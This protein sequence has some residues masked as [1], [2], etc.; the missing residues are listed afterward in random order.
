M[1]VVIAPDSFKECATAAAVSKAIAA[2]WLR[3]DPNADCVLVPMADGGEGTM[4]ALLAG[5]GEPLTVTVTG[6]LGE[7]VQAAYGLIHEGS[8]AVLEMAQAAGLA[9]VPPERRDP[10][11]TTTRGVGEMICHAL[12]RGVRKFLVGI[13]G[14][15][16]NDGGAG[17]AQALGYSLL[18]ADGRELP[19]GGAALVR[20]AHVDIGKRHPALQEC[21]IM[22]ACDVDNPLCGSRGASAVYGP[23]KGAT[24]SMVKELDA[25]LAHFA[26]VVKAKVPGS[27]NQDL[28]TIPGAGA[29]GGLGFGLL[30]FCGARMRR[31]VELVAEAAGLSEKVARADLV[32]TGEGRMDGQSAS[33]KTPVGVA[34]IARSHGVPVVALIGSLGSGYEAVY[35]A[36]IDAVV[37]ICPGPVALAE[38]M[39]NG[40]VLI[41]DAAERLARLWRVASQARS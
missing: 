22:I 38:A 11:L 20:L 28:A 40:E 25:A 37:P 41:R 12:D 23:Q 33:G 39:A 21:E 18:D 27:A 30:A 31:G 16:T 5:G 36:G 19:A 7:P 32:I 15:A 26:E 8:M 6:P 4:E 1:R 14:S 29:A 2:G 35:E 24:P 13:G 10:R 17:M 34:R 9:L 3:V